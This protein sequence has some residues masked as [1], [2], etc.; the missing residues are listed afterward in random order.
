MLHEES[1]CEETTVLIWDSL[2]DCIPMLRMLS[3]RPP[4]CAVEDVLWGSY[5]PLLWELS[6]MEPI[7]PWSWAMPWCVAP[8]QGLANQT[9]TH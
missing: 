1:S 4:T 3:G 9:R 6:C 2:W 8:A 5:V 7:W